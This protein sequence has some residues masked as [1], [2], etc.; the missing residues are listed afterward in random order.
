[1]RYLYISLLQGKI[2][3]GVEVLLKYAVRVIFTFFRLDGNS[4]CLWFFWWGRPRVGGRLVELDES[5]LQTTS[6]GSWAT[7]DAVL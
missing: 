4:F 1:M 7:L 6:Q 3:P 2:V 5:Q